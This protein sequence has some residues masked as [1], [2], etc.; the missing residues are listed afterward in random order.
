MN[1][2]ELDL[3]RAVPLGFRSARTWRLDTPDG[4][5]FLKEGG[6]LT[7]FDREVEKAGVDVPRLLGTTRSVRVYEWIDGR[8]LTADDDVS[9]W[10]GT[11]LARLHAIAP[12]ERAEPE[13]YGVHD[14]WEELLAEG[15]RRGRRWAGPLRAGLPALLATVEWISG[16]FAASGRYV[17]THRDVEPWNVMITPT[18]PVLIDW[19]AV[20]P[21]SAPLEAAHAAYAFGAPRRV[22]DAYEAA[23]GVPLRASPDLLV[24][25]IGLRLSRLT[26]RLEMSLGTEPLRAEELESVERRAGEQIESIPSFVAELREQGMRFRR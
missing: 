5:F 15:S 17:T 14:R 3:G 22:A 19:D 26:E 25:R 13:V 21:D 9:E 10:L 6:A 8:D 20:G 23:G 2:D 16:V 12:L 24:R 1:V 4:R 7:T 11:T 18:G